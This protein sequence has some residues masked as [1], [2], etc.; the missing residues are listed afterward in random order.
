MPAAKYDWPAWMPVPQ[1]A[2]YGMQ[3]V[4]RRTK[5]DM[6]IGSRLRAEFDT[7]ETTCTCKIILSDFEAGWLETFEH[8]VLAQGTIW[9]T[10]PIWSAGTVSQHVV[11]FKD[12]PRLSEIRGQHGVYEFSLDIAARNLLSQDF[13]E[14]LI[15]YSPETLTLLSDKL[16]HVLHVEMPRVTILPDTLWGM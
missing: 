15:Y 13:A 14:V 12:R 1:K 10:M 8:K 2:G 4:D 5:T 16:H 11:R 9:I 7:D 3:P 6:E